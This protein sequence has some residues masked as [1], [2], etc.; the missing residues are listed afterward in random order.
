MDLTVLGSV[1]LWLGLLL[2]VATVMWYHQIKTANAGWVDVFWSWATGVTG[3]VFLLSG[4]GHIVPR[5]VAGILLLIWSVRLGGHIYRRVSR[6]SHEDG[7]YAAMRQ[8]L[9]DRIQPVFL[10]FF[11]A[12]ALLA[13]GFALS[14]KVIGG[15]ADFHLGAVLLGGVLGVVAIGGEALADAQ[16]SRFRANPDHRGK[17]CREGLWRYTRHPN[18]FF[19]WLHWISYP[20][21]AIGASQAMWLWLLP[22]AMFLFLWFV[23]GIPYTEKQAIKTRGEDYRDYQRTTSAFFPWRPLS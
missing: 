9:G 13:I 5:L 7:R 21:I 2:L 6:E 16:L 3:C 15:Q 12:Q 10:I 23:T 8:A 19:E 20:L 17:T 18:Y 11:W 4:E 22:V 14:F 1:W